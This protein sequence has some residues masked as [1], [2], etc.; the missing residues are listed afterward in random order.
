[1]FSNIIHYRPF[2]LISTNRSIKREGLSNKFLARNSTIRV[3]KRIG[4]SLDD[5]QSFI[6]AS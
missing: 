2:S 3:Y 5:P 1:M 6:K 4:D